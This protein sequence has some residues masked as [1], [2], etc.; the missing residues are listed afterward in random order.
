MCYDVAYL[1][2]RLERYAEHYG[3]KKDWEDIKQRLPAT[4]H[5]QGFDHAD[6]PVITNDRP[7][8]VI[9]F[10]WGLV[11]RWVK[12]PMT[13]TKL[14]NATLNARAEDMFDKP[15]YRESARKRHCLIII[16]GFYEHHWKD[17]KSY[18]HFITLKS[19]EP[20]ALAGLWDTWN[21]KGTVSIVTTRAN[22]LMAKIHNNPKGSHEPR[23]PLIL[24]KD[25]EKAWLENISSQQ[26]RDELMNWI[27]PVDDQLLKAYTVP[28]LRGNAYKGNVPETMK[29]HPYPELESEQG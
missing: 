14:S 27:G 2:K 8:K 21:D 25:R 10:E 15:S 23:M 5:T 1:T 18:P 6:L 7:D 13:A 3:T 12:D 16:D 9:T 17:G 4:Y 20:F 24:P 29:P 22:S 26:E 11:P 19:E 28:R